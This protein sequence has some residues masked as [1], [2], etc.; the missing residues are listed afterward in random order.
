M[1]ILFLEVTIHI[2]Y[3]LSAVLILLGSVLMALRYIHT[4]LRDPLKPS[5]FELH[6]RYLTVG[7]EILI[8]AEIINTAA[9]R[10][11]EGFL[12]LILTIATRVMI[13][14]I[15]HMEEKWASK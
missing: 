2:L 7:L 6:A 12:V 4:K 14:F 13:A 8:G 11:L 3:V 1:I 10:T 9:T 15:L 5:K